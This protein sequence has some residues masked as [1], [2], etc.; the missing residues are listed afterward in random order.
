[1]FDSLDKNQKKKMTNKL[2]FAMP[3]MPEE[4]RKFTEALIT[5]LE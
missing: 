1:M 4:K 5:M 3:E 2:K